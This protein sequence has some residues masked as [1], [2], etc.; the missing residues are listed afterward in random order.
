[1]RQTALWLWSKESVNMTKIKYR[2]WL[3]TFSLTSWRCW[4]I[5]KGSVNG[6]SVTTLMWFYSGLPWNDPGITYWWLT[7][8]PRWLIPIRDGK[9]SLHPWE[10]TFMSSFIT[11][12]DGLSMACQC[13]LHNWILTSVLWICLFIHSM[14]TAIILNHHEIWISLLECLFVHTHKDSCFDVQPFKHQIPISLCKS[15]LWHL[16]HIPWNWFSIP[17]HV[18]AWVGS[19]CRCLAC[20]RL[21]V[22]SKSFMDILMTAQFYSRIG[23]QASTL[24]EHWQPIPQKCSYVHLMSLEYHWVGKDNKSS[25]MYSCLEISR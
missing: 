16:Q 14:N 15:S 1:M 23:N 13:D 19:T 18:H 4:I 6:L 10:F 11:V 7:D 21:Q 17:D 25:R 22:G 2:W 8:L 3:I 5:Y 20:S 24:P 9:V 12:R